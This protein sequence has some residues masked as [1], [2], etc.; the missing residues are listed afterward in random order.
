MQK[1]RTTDES[2][3]IFLR[4]IC[5]LNFFFAFFQQEN[6][7]S[8]IFYWSITFLMGSLLFW[9]IYERRGERAE[10]K[11]CFFCHFLLP[12]STVVR[13]LAEELTKTKDRTKEV[14]I[15]KHMLRCCSIWQNSNKILSSIR[16]PNPY[17]DT[18]F[19]FC[20]FAGSLFESLFFFS[21]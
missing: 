6:L 19:F 18:N 16:S 4:T 10:E 21:L 2:Q 9:G 7:F 13:C 17:F 1:K 8:F 14:K 11:K 3:E 20:S 15:S 5:K 12:A